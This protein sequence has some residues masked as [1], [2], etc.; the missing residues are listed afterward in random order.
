M[1]PIQ[2]TLRGKKVWMIDVPTAVW[3]KRTRLFAA[4][5]Q[6]VQQKF[7][8]AQRRALLGIENVEFTE[9]DKRAKRELGERGSLL[10]AVRF[11]LGSKPARAQQQ[12]GAAIEECVALKR[13]LNCRPAYLAHL[14][15]VLHQ[16]RGFIGPEYLCS[17]VL[18]AQ[19]Q[20]FLDSKPWAGSTLVGMRNRVSA[21]FS[22]AL[23]R[24]YVAANPCDTIKAPKVEKSVPRILSVRDCESL[25]TTALRSD[26]A[27]LPYLVLGMFCGLRPEELKRLPVSCVRLEESIVD[28]PASV[29]KTR[30]R[31]I[32]ELAP[33]ALAWL[34]A[35]RDRFGGAEHFITYRSR[36]RALA[37]A[38]GV[39]WSSDVM[40]H[41]FASYHIELHQSA[42][43][44]ALQLGHQGS[45]KMLFR[46]YKATV[47]K[48]EAAEFWALRPPAVIEVMEAAA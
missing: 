17:Q 20:R 28:I 41:S 48:Q 42:D 32:V 34:L 4:S 22:F 3:G 10:E 8:L 18:T 45:T 46:H 6:E 24:G 7:N 40:R 12:L 44:T 21:F 16:F 29:S 9:E 19:V 43:R 1:K 37:E 2:V 36:R 38:A 35:A 47:T 13:K 27:M 5:A 39:E 11:F 23:D 33:N 30:D 14:E 26:P 25:L 15:F 31:R